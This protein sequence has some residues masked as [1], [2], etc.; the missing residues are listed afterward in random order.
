MNNQ[1]L[2]CLTRNGLIAGVLTLLIIT[3]VSLVQGG[4][5]F[6]V[7]PLNAQ[8]GDLL[9]GVTSH[10]D[11]GGRC[12]LCH[13]PFW[14]DETMADRCAACHTDITA[15]RA[16]PSSLHGIIFQQDSSITCR[17]C[18]HDHRG[19]NA[20]LTDIETI[21]FPHDVV[22]YSLNGHQTNAEGLPFG[23]KDCHATGYTMFDQGV[24]LTCHIGIDTV[25]TTAH[26][27]AFGKNCLSCHD[28]VDTYGKGFDHNR[29]AFKLIGKHIGVD[30]V[31]C[32][33][34]ARSVL[35]LQSAPQTC[36][37]CHVKDDTHQGRLGTDCGSCHTPNGWAGADFDHNLASF[38]LE[39]KH[40]NVTCDQ[41]HINKV[42][43][44][45]PSECYACHAK[46]DKHDGRYTTLCYACHSPEGWT[47][48][49]VDHNLFGFKLQGR[50]VNVQCESCHINQVFKGTPTDC[51]SCHAKDDKHK[52]IFGKDCASCHTQDGWLPS[53][54]D[55]NQFG[56]K[57]EGRHAGVKCENCHNNSD[58]KSTPT[59][60]YACHA[61][62]DKHNG[63]FSTVCG[64]CHT[65]AG[66]LPAT[67][68][69]RTFPLAAGHGGLQ[70]TRCHSV[71]GVFTGLSTACASC[72]RDPA[73]HAGMFGYNCAQC[74]NTSN[75]NATYTGAHPGS[76]EGQCINHQGAG[77]RD[78]HTSSLSSATCSKC[79]D[80]NNP[81]GG[82]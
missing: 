34:A 41:C 54:I 57:L 62:D 33:V 23:C 7:G 18:H 3:V 73:F 17:S 24:C 44:G 72:H 64:A 28:G 4:V 79:H 52:G 5:L 40:V 13:A 15:Q 80:S 35:D 66:W 22:G 1:R 59:N 21:K 65:T 25:F 6:S 78:C 61:N 27:I 47:P 9:G 31:P 10:A 50:H 76:C 26:T 56:F 32:H 11:I 38:K 77:C 16:D 8:E 46:D 71:T 30:C 60:C 53:T 51:Y 2:G 82:D 43:Q 49:T 63:R 48:A 68:D 19:A 42:L 29:Y 70:C 81:G 67:F 45:T 39:G 14:S 36:S 20:P 69:H 74:H 55:H 12:K 37:A 75:W 58:L